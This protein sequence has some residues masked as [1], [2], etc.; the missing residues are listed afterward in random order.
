MGD[1]PVVS[2]TH[3]SD[4]SKRFWG[5]FFDHF[6]SNEPGIQ[7]FF[8]NDF[9]SDL[10]KCC[11]P[12]I[13]IPLFIF[14]HCSHYSLCGQNVVSGMILL[15][16]NNLNINNYFLQSPITMHICTVHIYL[17]Q[18]KELIRGCTSLRCRVTIMHAAK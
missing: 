11:Y 10:A 5:D 13:V 2:Q 6:F 3:Q 12:T 1:Y 8:S 15:G 16:S 18:A 7:S 14:L 4:S 17:A 9:S